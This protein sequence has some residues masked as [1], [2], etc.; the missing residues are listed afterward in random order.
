LTVPG[1]VAELAMPEALILSP[2]DS[3]W[4]AAMSKIEDFS[5]RQEE[6]AVV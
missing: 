1:L 3:I 2:D 4:A 5:N 6:H